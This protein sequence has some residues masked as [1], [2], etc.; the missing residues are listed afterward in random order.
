[1]TDENHS[2]RVELD[3][4][5]FAPE[6]RALDRVEKRGRQSIATKVRRRAQKAGRGRARAAAVGIL[7]G[8]RGI[9]RIR[10]T[11]DGADPWAEVLTPFVSAFQDFVDKQMGYSAR[12]AQRAREMVKTRLAGYTKDTGDLSAARADFAYELNRQNEIESGRNILRAHKDFQGPNILDLL[13]A[14]IPGY[15][16]LLWKSLKATVGI[17]EDGTPAK[18]GG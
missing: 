17:I 8:A 6:A 3:L 14:S 11:Y 13:A 9:S 7:G 15:F 10:R 18:R 1:M 4:T 5:E 2:V 12:A 16:E